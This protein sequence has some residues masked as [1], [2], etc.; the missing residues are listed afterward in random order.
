MTT[1]VGGTG[2]EIGE[3]RRIFP[4]ILKVLLIMI[5]AVVGGIQGI[6]TFLES[7]SVEIP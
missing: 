7:G 6:L 5:R 2:I 1:G 4:A 3:A